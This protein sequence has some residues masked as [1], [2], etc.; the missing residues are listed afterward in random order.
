[1]KEE[2]IGMGLRDGSADKHTGLLLQ[3]IQ[4][5]S[6]TLTNSSQSSVTTVPKTGPLLA[7]EG[8]RQSQ[9]TQTNT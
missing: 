1:M 3:S 7:S 4:V 8:T 6:V 5:Q 2:H 9:G